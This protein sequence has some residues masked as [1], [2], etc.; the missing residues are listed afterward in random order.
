MRPHR[1]IVLLMFIFA[2]V[3]PSPAEDAAGTLARI[4]ADKGVIAASELAMVQAADPEKRVQ[5][6]AS[7]LEEKGVLSRAEV[8]R[9][10]PRSD[11]SD[12]N[13]AAQ[14]RPAVY[15]PDPAPQ[16]VSGPKP[17]ESAPAVTSQNRFPV[18]IYGTLLTNAFYNTALTNIEDI[19]LFAGKQRYIF[20]VGQRCVIER[21][22]QERSINSYGEPVLRRNRRSAFRWFWTAYSLWSGVG[23]IHRG[24]QLCGK[25]GVRRVGA[26]H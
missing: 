4:L 2:L 21:V 22:R 12:S 14:L 5:L 10:M 6:L 8:A 1:W 18:T 20:D 9:L 15:K 11:A 16:A 23:L 3:T 24:P 17:A 25:I 7:I 19:P 13:L 26:R